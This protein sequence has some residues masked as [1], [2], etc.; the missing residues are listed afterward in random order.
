MIKC[1]TVFI[2][3][4]DCMKHLNS[5]EISYISGAGIK[6]DAGMYTL[7]ISGATLLAQ[8]MVMTGAGLASRNKTLMKAG[9]LTAGAGVAVLGAVAL[10]ECTGY[11][12][13]QGWYQ[14]AQVVK[15]YKSYIPG[16]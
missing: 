8:G 7:S 3:D 6:Q 2:E 1:H 10:S 9:A 12:D 14:F 11:S 16:F 13:M 5:I 4:S 15:Y